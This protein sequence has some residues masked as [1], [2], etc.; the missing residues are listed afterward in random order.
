MTLYFSAAVWC[1][2]ALAHVPLAA[3]QARITPGGRHGYDDEPA[4]SSW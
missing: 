2:I 3:W 1:S 4:N